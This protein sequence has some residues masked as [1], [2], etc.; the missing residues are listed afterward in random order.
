[1]NIKTYGFEKEFF[2]RTREGSLTLAPK[3]VSMD[4]CGYLAEARG[5]PH[6][7]PLTARHMLAAAVERLVSQARSS[8]VVL[9][10]SHAEDVPKDLIRQAIRAHG[11]GRASSFFAHGGVGYRNTKPRAGLHIHFGTRQE[12]RHSDGTSYSYTSITNMPRIIY[13]MDSAFSAEIKAAKRVAGEYEMKPWGFEYRS[14]PSTVD[15]DKV[16]A[17]LSSIRDEVDI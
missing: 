5:E 13:L 11:K 8:A 3:T 2:L 12:G 10:D 7:D 6:S 16:V 14:L 15:L 4:A 1:M 17:V 9:V